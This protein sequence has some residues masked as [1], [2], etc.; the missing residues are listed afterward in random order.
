MILRKEEN[1]SEN[2][3]Q[4]I[5]ALIVHQWLKMWDDVEF[6]PEERRRKPE[7]HF[8]VFTMSANM[9]RRLSDIYRRKTDQPRA[10]DPAIQRK[11]I[12]E[13]SYEIRNFIRGGF[14]WSGLSKRQQ[15]STDYKD[16]QMPGWLPTA[17][18]ANILAPDTKRGKA[19]I[20][21]NDVIEIEHLSEQMAKL[22]LPVAANNKN[23]NPK[24]SPIEIID[25]QHR[26][27]AFEGDRPPDGDYELPVVA[28]YNLDITW[29][30]YLFYMINIK[31]KR[32]DPSLAFD[33]YP[34]LRIQDWLEKTP[35]TAKIYR[36]TRAQE[37]TEVLWSHPESPWRNRIS[38][39]GERKKGMVT[40]SAFIRSLMASYVKRGRRNTIGGLFGSQ[41]LTD[42]EEFI[43]WDRAQQAAFL[44]LVWSVMAEAVK[45]CK[46]EW[47]KHLRKFPSQDELPT[48][49]G[50]VSD[51]AFI[52]KHSLLA[53]DQGA[54]GVLQ[55][56]NDMCYV[57]ANRLGLE[58]WEW[59]GDIEEGT[60][61][62]EMVSL[63]LQS[64]K[65][66]PVKDFLRGIA[67]E[68]VKFDW[69]LSSTPDLEENERKSQMI[70]R[71][72]GGYREL[73]RQLILLLKSAEN[74]QIRTTA[75]EASRYLG[76]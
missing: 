17:I 41:I 65:Q 51:P 53:T 75:S 46:E 59:D 16:L 67:N 28:F 47:A 26:L 8:Y 34:I 68:L 19:V 3:R 56:T 60:V 64:L 5:R 58:S 21:S 49:G 7:P 69:R 11:H 63:A 61:R 72:S 54:R 70:F 14:P 18:I 38:M 57:A 6:I 55:A 23:W 1:M 52:S 74:E 36:E 43:S 2:S 42:S 29:Q 24:V 40:Q 25:G 20:G 73:R 22:V 32:I 33:L 45:E 76:F 12:P 31:P 27:L 4:E 35:E 30:A 44:I 37:L 50:Y 13:R 62:K 39:L 10:Q 48:M 9:L 15:Q 66:L 71:G